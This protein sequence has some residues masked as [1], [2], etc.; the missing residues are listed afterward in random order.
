M[1]EQTYYLDMIP[2]ESAPPVVHVSQFDVNSRTLTFNLMKG[3]VAYEP[4][5][6]MTVTLDGTKP[7]NTAFS[8]PMTV[9]GSSVSIA[10]QT[11]MT[12]VAG[13]VRCEVTVSNA[14]GQIGSA[15]FILAVEESAIDTGAISDTDIPIFE[16]LKNQ[17]QQAAAEA[18]AAAQTVS[19]I[20]PE[21]VGTVGQV[22][23][24]TGTGAEWDDVDGLPAGGTVGQV[25]T[26]NS[27]TDG[28]A[29]W[30][31]PT[32][33]GTW[34]SI[35]GTISDQT[36]LQDELDDK[37]DL[38]YVETLTGS[39]ATIEESP[40]TANHAV[41][42]FIVYNGQL[43]SVIS[44]IT[45]GNALV[46]GTNISA[47]S[48]G[49]ELTTL[50]N[51]LNVSDISSNFT[52]DS[53]YVDNFCANKT[54]KVAVLSFRIKASC[55]NNTTLVTMSNSVKP[56]YNDVVSPFFSSNGSI[57]TQGSAWIERNNRSVITYYGSSNMASG[58]YSTITYI[59]A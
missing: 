28:D 30:Q 42:D 52:I 59:I 24:K 57:Q 34:G 9:D 23:T 16:D 38:T 48:A 10:L 7:D 58:S 1:I 33:G 35:T 49:A 8:Y 15:N 14:S 55:P 13:H 5:I 22:L 43:Y 44:A 19:A 3:G 37:A 41:G 2:G 47:T 51:G 29:S 4:D 25:L 11:Q 17:A 50:K 6:G 45:A 53:S 46:V 32:G 31:N 56:S 21:N 20:L 26:K 54:G 36:D 40:A 18:T 27:S 39:V 12:V